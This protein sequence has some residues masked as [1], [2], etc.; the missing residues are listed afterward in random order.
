MKRMSDKKRKRMIRIFTI[1]L[2]VALAA[3]LAFGPIMAWLA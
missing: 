2:V 1:V 3:V